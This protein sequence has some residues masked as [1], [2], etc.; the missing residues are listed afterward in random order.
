MGASALYLSFI[1]VGLLLSP[2]L[3]ALWN[4]KRKVDL[5]PGVRGES[6]SAIGFR[7]AYLF[8]WVLVIFSILGVWIPFWFSYAAKLKL[9]HKLTHSIGVLAIVITLPVVLMCLLIYGSKNGYL[10]RIESLNWPDKEN[11]IDAEK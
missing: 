1:F 7:D 11:Q 9:E 4:V 2:A 6:S 3:V 8:N 10:K 5:E